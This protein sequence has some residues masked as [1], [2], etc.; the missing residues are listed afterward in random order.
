MSAANPA[1]TGYLADPSTLPEQYAL[2]GRGTCM[3]PLIEDGDLLVFDRT[4]EVKKGDIVGILLDPAQVPEDK[5]PG[6][7]KRLLVGPPPKDFP[8]GNACSP[9]IIVEMLN[10]PRCM[11]I[12]MSK[13]TGIHK[14]LGK[15]ERGEDGFVQFSP[16]KGGFQ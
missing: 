3:S 9:A 11:S 1:M 2:T 4:A 7:V 8:F 16:S 15:A 6:F 5:Y 12:P 13:V 10:P 14:C